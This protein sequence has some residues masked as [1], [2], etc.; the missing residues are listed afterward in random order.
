[1]VQESALDKMFKNQLTSITG[2]HLGLP[3]GNEKTLHKALQIKGLL[4][5]GE[6]GGG[7][8][9][10]CMHD[11]TLDQEPHLEVASEVTFKHLVLFSSTQWI[12]PLLL[13][14]HMAMEIL[15]NKKK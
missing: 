7:S 8:C 6:E 3:Q 12:L 10:N 9:W 2:L 4:G 1:M 14:A 5:G 11:F 13:P 15:I